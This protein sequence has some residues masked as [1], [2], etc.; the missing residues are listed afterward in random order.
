MPACA[1]ASRCRS[2]T[3]PC[4]VG[5]TCGMVMTNGHGRVV[6]THVH[7]PTPRAFQP[8]YELRG[9]YA[10]PRPSFLY[11]T[12]RNAG[13]VAIVFFIIGALLRHTGIL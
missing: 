11:R 2:G 5:S 12:V 4:P 7:E 9:P 10:R 3:R 6:D 13:A 1:P 8:D